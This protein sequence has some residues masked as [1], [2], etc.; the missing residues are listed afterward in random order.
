MKKKF[1]ISPQSYEFFSK[2][3]QLTY[4]NY[5]KKPDFK[6]FSDLVK[7]GIV[8]RPHY[9]LGLLLAA[10]QAHDLGLKEI[11]VLEL[12]CYNFDGI[13]DLENYANDIKK[14]L[15]INIE[16][17]GFTLKSGLP[18]YKINNF[19]RLSRWDVG[20]YKFDNKTN[21]NNLKSSKI[22]F[23]EIK[24]T[25]PQFVKKYKKTF[26]NSPIGFVMFDLDYYT[27]TKIGLNLLKL[28]ISNY[29]PRTYAY[30]DDHSFSSFDEGERKAIIEFNKIS[31]YKI[32]DIGELAE[33][34]SIF[35][36]KW[37]FLGKRLKI[38]NYH[39]HSKFNEKINSI[40][41]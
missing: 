11:K 21:Y 8:P 27:S 30:F 2:Q 3:N 25:I 13:I 31:K 33:Q 7:K 19:D 10:K 16:I 9:A 22:F 26:L 37:I 38:I 29:L 35:F 6:K 1:M 4:K 36:N 17:F 12:G 34:L 5:Q 23:G 32:S 18:K 24:N 15:N 20:D 39:N 40:Y 41:G 14:F 28:N